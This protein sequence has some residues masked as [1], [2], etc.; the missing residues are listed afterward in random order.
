[1]A[2]FNPGSDV[3]VSPELT[4]RAQ[5]GEKMIRLR[6]M[7]IMA[8][9]Q[10]IGDDGSLLIVAPVLVWVLVAIYAG[11]I[12]LLLWASITGLRYLLPRLPSR[13]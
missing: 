7:P 5:T 2:D 3:I 4:Q 1:M 6:L 13:W 12:H 11:L 9:S 8:L 10:A